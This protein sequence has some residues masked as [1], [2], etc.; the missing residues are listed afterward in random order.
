MNDSPHALPTAEPLA[1]DLAGRVDE[2][3]ARFVES[4]LAEDVHGDAFKSK[5]DSAFHLGREEIAATAALLNGRFMSRA[6]IGLGDSSAF[7]AIATLRRQLDELNPGDAGDLLSPRRIL[8]FIP[9]GNRLRA[10]LRRFQ[11]AGTQ[12]QAAVQQIYA[13]C[14]DLQRDGVEID[15]C[16]AK[17]WEAMQKLKAAICFAEELDARL[18]ARIASLKTNDPERARALEQEVLFYARQNRSDML[19]QHAVCANGYLSL[20][21]L[22]KTCRETIVGCNRVA[23]TGMSALSVAHTVACATGRQVKVMTMLTGVNATVENLLVAS[24]KELRA[25]AAQTAR[26]ASNPLLGIEK[27]KEAFDLTFQAMDEMDGFRAKALDAMAQ[28]SAALRDEIARAETYLERTRREKARA[29]V[30]DR[31]TGPVAL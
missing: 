12:L 10:Y 15:A 23:T 22:K 8:G 28:S 27:L 5:L 9:F 20:D 7:Q 3:V 17:L 29:V 16:R 26:F 18:A 19:T 13:A 6:A 21:V 1:P 24:G 11:G 14:D 4:L 2:Q 30:R 25:H 31:I